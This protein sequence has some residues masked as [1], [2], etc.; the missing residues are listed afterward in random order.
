[1]ADTFRQIPNSEFLIPNSSEVAEWSAFFLRCG[2]LRLYPHS[3]ACTPSATYALVSEGRAKRLAIVSDERAT[4]E[5]FDGASTSVQLDGRTVTLKI[6]DL[7][8][9]HA[10][11]LRERLDFLVPRPLGLELS[12]G[13]GDRLGLAT[14]G[15]LRAFRQSSM[16][17]ILAQQSMRENA[18]TG[19]SPQQV[20]DDAMWGVFQEGW[21]RGYGAD[22]DHLKSTGDID[23]CAPAGYTLYTIDP[24]EH[25]DHEANVAS[26]EVLREKVARLPWSDLDTSWADTHAR[27]SRRLDLRARG[28]TASEE[29][30]LRAAAKYGRMV[31]HTVAMHRHLDRVMSGRP[32]EME[33]SVDESDTVTTLTEHIYIASELKRLGVAWVSLA[34]RYV[35]EFEKGVDYRGDVQAFERTFAE[36]VAVSEALGPYKLSLHSGSDKF[37]IFPIAAR[38]AGTRVHLKTSGTSYLEALRAIAAIDAGLFRDIAALARARYASDRVGYHVSADLARM[39]DV[40]RLADGQLSTILDDFDGR[41]I[42]HVTFGSVIQQHGLR[43]RLLADLREHDDMYTDVIEA[44]FVRHFQPFGSV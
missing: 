15:H 40:D 4:L 14:P 2:G 19:R 37:S 28:F 11:G 10:A 36:H 3:V 6:S 5:G 9:A 31:A 23:R 33:V 17:P 22:A 32:F 41:E 20:V 35:G 30:L 38:V 43:A 13:C 21:R 1:M 44:H 29:Q 16:A 26:P 25:V 24:S 39:P 12:A 27:L 34:P 8:A 42:L 18:R 7:T